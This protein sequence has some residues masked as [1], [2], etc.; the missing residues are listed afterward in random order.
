MARSPKSDKS[1]RSPA[2][3]IAD[4]AASF[5]GLLERAGLLIRLERHLHSMLDPELAQHFRVANLRQNRLILLARLKSLFDRI[6]DLS[7]LG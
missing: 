1:A 6:A 3:I 7:V 4:P 2:D 5:G